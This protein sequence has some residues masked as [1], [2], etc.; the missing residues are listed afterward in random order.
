MRNNKNSNDLIEKYCL[1]DSLESYDPYDIWKTNLG[2]SVKR[3]FIRNRYLGLLPAAALTLVD[4]YVNNKFR[5]F[6][7]KQEY[8]IVRAQASL[9]LLNLYERNGD[10]KFLEYAK[11]HIDWLLKNHSTGYSGLCWGTGFKI[12]V[13]DKLVYDENTPFTTN[14][15]YALE[16][17]DKYYQFT[18]DPEV[19]KGIKSVF[20]FYEKDIPIMEENEDILVTSYGPFKDRVVINAVSYTMYAYAIF[21]KYFE[22]SNYIANKISKMYQFVINNQND[23][24]SWFYDFDENSFIDCFHSCFV[25]KNIFKTNVIYELNNVDEVLRKGY[26][27]VK[28]SCYDEKK[29]LFKRFAK[30]NKPSIVKFDLYDNGEVLSLAKLLKDEEIVGTLEQKIEASF[31]RNNSLYSVIDILGLKKNKDTLR[32]AVMPYV[33]AKSQECIK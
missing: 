16:A 26:Q 30:E 18:N 32:W 9:A 4:Y 8:P 13:S 33:L 2:V 29:G 3:L 28:T 24:G 7:K 17:L 23:D 25:L 19:L 6:Y 31:I 1:R 14:T 5:F 21:Y 15:P 27:Y 12:V 20:D 22:E 11:K 10:E